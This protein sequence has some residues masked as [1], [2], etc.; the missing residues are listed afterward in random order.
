MENSMHKSTQVVAR[1][2]IGHIFLLAGLS[3][4]GSIDGTMTYME[5]MGVTGM[6]IYP[7]IA[8]EIL[9]GL[10]IITGWFT[11]VSSLA[12]A[13]FT[14]IAAVI[15]HSNLGD[16]MQMILFMKN[17]A[18]TGGLLLLAIYGAGAYSIDNRRD[19]TLVSAAG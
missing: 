11:R 13:G 16:Q 10:A 12:L 9:G 17:I 5:A 19:S 15:F 2:M 18:I 7:T 4:L 14:I 3:K 1:L 6:L 8:L